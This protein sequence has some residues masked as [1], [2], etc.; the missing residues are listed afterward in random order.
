MYL[1]DECERNKESFEKHLSDDCAT[2]PIALG[3]R[4]LFLHLILLRR[5]RLVPLHHLLHEPDTQE[6]TIKRT[7]MQNESKWMC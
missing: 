7:G 3:P 1:L 2:S 4:I 5:Q 6:E